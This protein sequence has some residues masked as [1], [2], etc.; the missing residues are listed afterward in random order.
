MILTKLFK[1][2]FLF[3]LINSFFSK[4]FFKRAPFNY[5]FSKGGNFNGISFFKKIS[6]NSPLCIKKPLIFKLNKVRVLNINQFIYSFKFFD[7]LDFLNKSKYC[8]YYFLFKDNKLLDI[9]LIRTSIKQNKNFVLKDFKKNLVYKIKNNR[10]LL[11]NLFFFLK[12]SKKITFFINFF[13]NNYIG[14]FKSGVSFLKDFLLSI[15]FFFNRA[16]YIYFLKKKLI[17][18]NRHA[19]SSYFI[20]L[21]KFDVVHFLIQNYLCVYL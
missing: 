2:L 17:F 18:L 1:F 13:K 14:L 19:V 16:A 7:D 6:L 15:F 11:K 12:N 21:K 3:I 10:K 9:P 20:I 5:I 8:S 4:F